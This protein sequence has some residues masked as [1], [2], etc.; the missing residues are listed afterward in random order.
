MNILSQINSSWKKHAMILI[1]A[2]II[3][4]IV[5]ITNN[6]YYYTHGSDWK[7]SV[8]FCFA[9]TTFDWLAYALIN[10]TFISRILKRKGWTYWLQH[11]GN[12]LLFITITAILFG[13][14]IMVLTMKLIYGYSGQDFPKSDYIMNSTFCALFTLIFTLMAYGSEF[15]KQWK[16]SINENERMQHE[17]QRSQYELLKSQVN[18]HFLFNSL[19]TLITIIPEKPEVAVSFVKQL[20]KVFRYALIHVADNTVSV[21]TELKIVDAYLFL[22]KERYGEKLIIDIQLDE[23]TLKLSLITQSLLMLVENAIKHN[24]LSEKHPLTINIYNEG[25]ILIIKNTLQLKKLLDQSTG[26]GLNNIISR[27]KHVTNIPVTIEKEHNWFI[28]KLP[29]LQP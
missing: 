19:N 26:I 24:E 10:K 25:D 20:S 7:W 5:N 8:S 17:M 6:W 16:L 18:P 21:A 2:Y 4:L 9:I 22:N 29:L 11:P 1:I 23:R 12:L 27:Y 3:V 28:V 13:I 14:I 15:I